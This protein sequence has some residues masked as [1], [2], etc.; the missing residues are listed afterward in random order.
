LKGRSLSFNHDLKCRTPSILIALG[1][2]R[3]PALPPPPEDSPAD[4]EP[5]AKPHASTLRPCSDVVRQKILDRVLVR[6]WQ[7]DSPRRDAHNHN[8][9]PTVPSREAAAARF[10]PVAAAAAAAVAVAAERPLGCVEP[11]SLQFPAESE[12]IGAR[13]RHVTVSRHLARISGADSV[14]PAG[15]VLRCGAAHLRCG[16]MC[17][18]AVC[19]KAPMR[20][21]RSTS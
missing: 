1:P 14:A 13:P 4:Y 16:A 7:V 19:P 21:R 11:H 6:G 12:N 5:H 20:L 9:K 8:R 10:T 18:M 3:S 15:C 2:K 17:A